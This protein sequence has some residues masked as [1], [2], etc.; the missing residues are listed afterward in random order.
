MSQ[1]SSNVVYY[2]LAQQSTLQQPVYLAATNAATAW[3]TN[4][5]SQF[6]LSNLTAATTSNTNVSTGLNTAAT[7]ST[8]AVYDLPT[9]L[10]DAAAPTTTQQLF[11]PGLN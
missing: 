9:G 3:P 2:P 11:W 1:F 8:Q 10:F 7:A 5:F 6:N 4:L